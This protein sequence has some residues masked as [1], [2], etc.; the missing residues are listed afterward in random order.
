MFSDVS[1]SYPSTWS[2][3]AVE[4]LAREGIISRN[5]SDRYGKTYFYPLKHIS[6]IET[7]A[8]ML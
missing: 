5:N 6:Q 8:V 7:L 4:T 2:C 1:A 3:R